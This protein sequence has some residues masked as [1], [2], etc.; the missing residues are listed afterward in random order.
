[1]TDTLTAAPADEPRRRGGRRKNAP[2][3]RDGVMKRGTTWSYV[4]RVKDPETE[5]ASPDGS[6]ALPPR[7]PPRAPA[8]R[9]A[10]TPGRAST[11]IVTRSPSPRT[12]INGSKPTRSWS[13]PRRCRTTVT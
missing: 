4:I 3:L 6:A 10:S 8:T 11:S 12:S 1:M 5:S 7:K 9:H 2:R 13:S